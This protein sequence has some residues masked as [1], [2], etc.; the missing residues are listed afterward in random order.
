MALPGYDPIMQAFTGIMSVTGTQ[1]GPPVRAG[2]SLV[3]LSTG[4]WAAL[5]VV[6]AL[7]D[8][9]RS[10]RGSRVGVSL[11]ETA[12]SWMANAI[13]QYWASGVVPGRFG[14][15]T[16]FTA[17]YES[18]ATAD[19]DVMI[20]AGNDSFFARL[21]DAL[22]HPEWS[23]DNRFRRVPDRVVNRAAL[24]AVIEE[25]T[26][27]LSSDELVSALRSAAV[28]C[29]PIRDVSE[30]VKDAQAA[31]LG[32]FQTATH[33]TIPDFRS[34]GLP[35]RFEDLRPPLR[36]SPPLVGADT[37]AI[38]DEL[39]FSPLEITDLRKGGAIQGRVAAVG[40]G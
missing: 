22:G 27:A 15:G 8:R 36:M 20:A 13:T 25:V 35:L 21:S 5:G 24:H 30:V 28:P 40:A 37:D 38:L 33:S 6:T 12:L 17:P 34:V 14:S 4:M 19:G 23:R 11:Y 9:E 18:F 32:M 3:D 31:E 1:D 10:G 7:M 16:S 39:G 29:A 2:V 26:A